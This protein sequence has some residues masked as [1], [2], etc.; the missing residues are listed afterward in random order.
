MQVA[1]ARADRTAIIFQN[2]G[3]ADEKVR[4]DPDRELVS[5]TPVVYNRS[6]KKFTGE[7]AKKRFFAVSD[8]ASTSVYYEEVF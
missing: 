3:S 7:I 8:T 1:P 6:I 2:E 4:I 5:N